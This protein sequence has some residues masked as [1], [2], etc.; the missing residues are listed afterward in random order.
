MKEPTPPKVQ[1]HPEL[2]MH[3]SGSLLSITTK[4][5]TNITAQYQNI[6]K[7]KGCSPDQTL[8][9]HPGGLI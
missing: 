3:F 7:R 8:I 6:G 9:S 1:Q 2:W 4:L 5:N